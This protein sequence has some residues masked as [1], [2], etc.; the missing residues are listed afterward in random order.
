[1]TESTN[2]VVVLHNPV[3]IGTGLGPDTEA[4]IFLNEAQAREEFPDA[5][6]HS[7]IFLGQLAPR[8]ILMEDKQEWG[9][10]VG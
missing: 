6:W 4:H 5:V 10:N 3:E 8:N 9:Q 2:W 7:D 1:M